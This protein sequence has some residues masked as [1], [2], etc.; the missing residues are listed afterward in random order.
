MTYQSKG[1]IIWEIGIE[2]TLPTICWCKEKL[3]ESEI[4]TTISIILKDVLINTVCKN[5]KI[6]TPLCHAY[7]LHNRGIDDEDDQV[8]H[9]TQFPAKGDDRSDDRCKPYRLQQYAHGMQDTFQ[10]DQGTAFGLRYEQDGNEDEAQLPVH[11]KDIL[12]Y[13][14]RDGGTCHQSL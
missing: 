1:P 3:S 4:L 10:K 12:P 13:T 8:P 5:R 9:R 14:E 6:R 11:I 2:N 7:I